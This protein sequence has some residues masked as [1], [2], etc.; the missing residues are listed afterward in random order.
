ME[1]SNENNINFGKY[2]GTQTGKTIEITGEDAVIKFHSDS[3][4][5]EKGFSLFFT[6]VLPSTCHWH[7]S[8]IAQIA[9]IS[10]I[11]R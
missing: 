6:A 5:Q 10:I 9:K 11:T 2:C 3:A 8:F 1:I 7:L 4:D